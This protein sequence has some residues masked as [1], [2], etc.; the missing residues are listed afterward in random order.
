[1]AP[2]KKK[3]VSNPTI[4]VQIAA[5]R[6]PELLNTLRD[7]IG[8]ATHP[9]R[10]QFAIGWQ[11]SPYEQ[12]DNLDEYKD[13][14]R[15]H[16]ID[17]DYRDAKGPCWIRHKLN[18]AYNGQRYTLQLDS[19]HRFEPNWDVELIGMLE[20]LRSKEHPLPVLTSY[21]PSF[22][23][24]KDPE[25]RTNMPWVMEFD[26]F[27]PEGPVHFLPHTIDNFKELDKPIPTR[28][29]S[30]HFIFADGKF[31]QD[32]EYDPNYYFHGEEINLSVR[33]YMAGYDL[34][35][36]HRVFIW[37]EYTR[38]NKKKHWDDHK[39]WALLDRD[40]YKHGRELLG[41]DNE[42][43]EKT[44]TK[45]KR[46]LK[47]YEMYAG[48][49]FSTRRVHKETL[50]KT[51]PPISL[52]EQSHTE[53]LVSYHRMCIDLYKPTFTENDYIFWAV[54]FTDKD[55]NEIHREDA[56][57]EEIEKILSVPLET[58]KFIH[59]WRSF[60][61]EQLPHGWVVWPQSESKGFTE[62]L[63]GVFRR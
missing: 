62:R 63:T 29:A 8:K 61:S 31:C 43:S 54:A 48:L 12:W 13:D 30:G 14:S 19:H 40:S 44:L 6:D 34:F 18:T 58:D 39:D 52:D 37:H 16:I 26:R 50:K 33:A 9:E 41:M 7:C 21:L 4:Y 2:R 20:N 45:S 46:T 27:A 1:M 55:G 49:E 59:I 22:D 32:V 51:I 10:L 56:T 23:P 38:N 47:E 57:K 28:F 5:Y 35:A 17:I 24:A 42:M 53:H 15:F 36:P 25:G 3:T 11:H 60:H